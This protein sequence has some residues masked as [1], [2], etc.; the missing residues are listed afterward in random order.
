MLSGIHSTRNLAV[1]FSEILAEKIVTDLII[2]PENRRNKV[3]S[4][5]IIFMISDSYALQISLLSVFDMNILL[6]AK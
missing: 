5:T 4:K 6:S 3:I 1:Y 2:D